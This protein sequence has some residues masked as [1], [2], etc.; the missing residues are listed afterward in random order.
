M[1]TVASRLSG[2]VKEEHRIV[3]AFVG[4]EHMVQCASDRR[5]NRQS[6]SGS[7]SSIQKFV[8]DAI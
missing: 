5:S 8:R 7:V 6:H 3:Q 4:L 2:Q 1:E